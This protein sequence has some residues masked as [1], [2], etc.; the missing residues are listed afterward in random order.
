MKR[1]PFGLDERDIHPLKLVTFT[2]PGCGWQQTHALMPES[3]ITCVG[4]KLPQI[5]PG[6][7]VRRAR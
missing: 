1:R 5:V 7:R 4:C 6:W 3:T 2:C